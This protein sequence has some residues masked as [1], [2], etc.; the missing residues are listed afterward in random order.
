MDE[1]NLHDR[2]MDELVAELE[3]YR[4]QRK[5]LDTLVK[6][7]GGKGSAKRTTILNVVF[8]AALT[9]LFTLDVLRHF[10]EFT[11]IPENLSLQIGVVMISLKVIWLAHKR[12]QVEHFQ[13]WIM[14]SLELRINQIL[15]EVKAVRKAE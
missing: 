7:I 1:V 8:I 10:M 15:D 13:F 2:S 9:I 11:Y 6:E 3:S 5:A 12:N 4:R 14:N